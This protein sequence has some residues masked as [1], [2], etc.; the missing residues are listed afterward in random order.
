MSCLTTL[1]LALLTTRA[2]AHMVMNLPKPLSPELATTFPLDPP[3]GRYPFPC[4]GLTGFA[5]R[6]RLVPGTTTTVNFTGAAPHGGGSCQFGINYH[7]GAGGVPY[8]VDDPSHWKT[9]YTIVGGCPAVTAGNLEHAPFY[10]GLDPDRRPDAVHCGDAEGFD[11]TRQFEVPIP[12]GLPA[13]EATFAWVWHNRITAGEV[14]M[15][16]AP[17]LIEAEDTGDEGFLE[18]LPGMFFANVEGYTNCSTS[19]TGEQG[20]FNIPR[21]GR[22]GVQLVESDPKAAGDCEV[23]PPPVFETQEVPTS[24]A[25]Q[26]SAGFTTT[27]TVTVTAGN[28]T[29]SPTSSGFFHSTR[30]ITASVG[31]T[32]TT[33]LASA[34]PPPTPSTPIFLPPSTPSPPP[35]PADDPLA[36]KPPCPKPGHLVCLG[37]TAFAICDPF[38]VVGAL[39]HLNPEQ[40]FVNGRVVLRGV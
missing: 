32:T 40:M 20:V 25:V 15:T 27:V 29:I 36:P 35:R 38:G 22:F 30:T 7:A 12:R 11:C 23:A 8:S 31:I 16:C 10:R 14:Y 1:L 13:G 24:T 2:H 37:E 6:T 17:V 18:E 33:V 9:I 28:T 34:V 26:P 3:G 19:K 21:P 39:Q 5:S 4:T